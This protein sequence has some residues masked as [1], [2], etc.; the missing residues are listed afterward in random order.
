VPTVNPGEIAIAAGL[1]DRAEDGAVV[2][3]QFADPGHE[4]LGHAVPDTPSVQRATL[5]PAIAATPPAT[6]TPATAGAQP[7][8]APG[9]A[10]ADVDELARRLYDP[11]AARLKDEL[12][13]DRERAGFL[14]DLRH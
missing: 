11:L 4:Q 3:R 12:R 2:F 5:E 8:A 14:T 13:L 6:A 10:G 7:G 9:T 1:A